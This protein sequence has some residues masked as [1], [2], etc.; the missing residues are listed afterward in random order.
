MTFLTCQ[1]VMWRAF[2]L[3]HDLFEILVSSLPSFVQIC[4]SLA[5]DDSGLYWFTG[6]YAD[7]LSLN[8]KIWL[9]YCLALLPGDSWIVMCTNSTFK[10]ISPVLSNSLLSTLT[11]SFSL[12]KYL[13][14]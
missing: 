12:W 2:I 8:A 5:Y 6:L 1:G 3:L 9:T 10:V 7:F 13:H 4:C 11:V 14:R